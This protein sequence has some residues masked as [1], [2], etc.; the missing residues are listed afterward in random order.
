MHR[1]SLV[2]SALAAAA[3]QWSNSTVLAQA[4]PPQPQARPGVSAPPA[5][6]DLAN[7]KPGRAANQPVD[8]EYTRKIKEY[9][10]EPFFLSPLVDYL[11]ASSTV[12]TPKAVLGDIA[13][14]PTKLPYS[15]EVYAYMRMLEKASPRVK[16]F[17]IGTTEEGREM[18]AVAVASDELI[19]RLDENRAMLAQLADPRAINMDDAR[20]ERIT[21]NAAPVYYI[22]GTIHSPEDRK[23]VV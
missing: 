17:S 11:P 10:T 6:A 21:Q 5:P 1:H 8:E 23:S 2:A 4:P 3:L 16:V 22:T 18:I 9:T 13:G 7:A 15:K 14:A 20:A 19:S 12:P